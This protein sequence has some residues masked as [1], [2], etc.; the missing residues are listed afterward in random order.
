MRPRE[1]SEGATPGGLRSRRP[2]R[3][4][5]EALHVGLDRGPHQLLEGIAHDI[6]ARRQKAGD[7]QDLCGGGEVGGQI[8]RR[9]PSELGP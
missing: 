2:R 7:A 9:V 1:G 3:G 5:A 8:T 4:G 6:V